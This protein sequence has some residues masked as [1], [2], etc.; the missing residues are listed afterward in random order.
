MFSP[1][2]DEAEF[3]K[4]QSALDGLTKKPL[5]YRTKLS[6]KSI[7]MRKVLTVFMLFHFMMESRFTS[8][9][10]ERS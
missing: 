8:K 5:K 6:V 4:W 9:E 10:T 7:M 1:P 2:K 3:A